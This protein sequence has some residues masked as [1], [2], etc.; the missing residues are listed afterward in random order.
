MFEIDQR[1]V[2]QELEK[3][4][5]DQEQ[6]IKITE[7]DE[8]E[9]VDFW[10]NIWEQR[11]DH[12]KNADW[13]NQMEYNANKQERLAINV[14]QVRKQIKKMNNWKA[15]G[16]DGIHPY[17]L[18]AFTELHQL[19]ADQMNDIIQSGEVPSWLTQG[20]TVLIQKD[21]S[22]GNS[23]Y[24]FRPITCLSILWK[25]LTGVIADEIY[26][27]LENENLLMKK[28]KGC[29]SGSRKPSTNLC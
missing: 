22:K 3:T 11:T 16:P 8:K 18:K 9:I 28:Q 1:R 20:R 15:P 13:I 12:N 21:K 10:K 29:T 14:E 19:I 26:K 7:H 4:T 27:H 17:W 23:P 2:Y 24:N 5:P 25:L 6:E